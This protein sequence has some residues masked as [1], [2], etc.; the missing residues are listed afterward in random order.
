VEELS[1]EITD[2]EKQMK[3]ES[4]AHTLALESE[5]MMAQ[6]FEKEL[7]AEKTKSSEID[8][9]F[10]ALHR[11]LLTVVDQRDEATRRADAERSERQRIEKTLY[12]K[13]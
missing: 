8:R 13:T 11:E 4:D 5:Q 3:A 10:A 1:G 2:L 7:E 12:S 6:Q 9:S